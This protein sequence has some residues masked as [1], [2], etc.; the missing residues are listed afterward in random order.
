MCQVDIL[1]L[2]P[3][4]AERPKAVKSQNG[5][6]VHGNPHQNMGKPHQSARSRRQKLHFI[7]FRFLRLQSRGNRFSLENPPSL[8]G[9]RERKTKDQSSKHGHAVRNLFRGPAATQRLHSRWRL[10][11]LTDEQVSGCGGERR[12]ERSRAELSPPQAAEAE[13]AE[14]L[15]TTTRGGECR[16]FPGGSPAI[17]DSADAP[18]CLGRTRDTVYKYAGDRKTEEP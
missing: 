3:Y 10:R 14:F 8:R 2:V 6:E 4:N 12:K 13:W 5:K 18:P 9:T 15:P 16:D 11:R 1:P 7:P 17:D